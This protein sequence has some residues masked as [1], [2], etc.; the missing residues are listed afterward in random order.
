[1][2]YN[3]SVAAA[4]QGLQ[5]FADAGLQGN[6]ATTDARTQE[7]RNLYQFGTRTLPDLNSAYAA[8]GTFYGGSRSVAGG[9]AAED[10][11]NANAD[12]EM[13]LARTLAGLRRS[14]ILAATGVAV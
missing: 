13:N 5:N 11:N 1:M 10:L 4:M 14:G 3:G 2:A 7:A 6:L 9:R 12:L 8:K